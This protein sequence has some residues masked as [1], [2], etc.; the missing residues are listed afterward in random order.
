MIAEPVP[1]SVP[2]EKRSRTDYWLL[3]GNVI[4][5][6]GAL[7]PG[8]L[9]PAVT[10]AT[11]GT[12]I[13]TTGYTA[14]IR[15]DEGY[16][17]G[18]KR[19]QLAAGYSYHGDQSTGDYEEDHLI[20][21]ELGGAPSDPRNLWPE[22]YNAKQGAKAKDLVENK[23]HDLVCS[24]QLPLALAQRDIAVDW[25]AALRRYGGEGSPRIWDGRYAGPTGQPGSPSASSGTGAPAG[26]T[27]LCRDGTYSFS[28]HRSGTCAG[29]GGVA[30][31]LRH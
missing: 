10:Q 11:I 2:G 21:L 27:A 24:H 18:L 28:A 31:W 22:P 15:P 8:A 16:T 3:P 25:W 12:T 20:S 9:N 19:K 23:L 30:R 7:T 14:T 4:L 26:A 13:C 1:T 5:P 6:N 17:T 29:H